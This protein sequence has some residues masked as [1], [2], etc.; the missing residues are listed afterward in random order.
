MAS[1]CVPVSRCWEGPVP[2]LTDPAR[3]DLSGRP[4]LCS[5]CLGPTVDTG[6]CRRLTPKDAQASCAAPCSLLGAWQVQS[7]EGR[8]I[9]RHL[10]DLAS[11]VGPRPCRA[12]RQA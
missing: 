3:R 5:P 7:Q 11:E 12:P 1:V 4:S 10:D 8:G 6:V 9:A 2:V